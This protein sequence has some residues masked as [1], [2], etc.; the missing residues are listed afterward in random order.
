M[1]ETLVLAVVKDHL[2]MVALVEMVV[3]VVEEEDVAVVLV[4]DG[5][6]DAD[7]EEV[8][9]EEK[10]VGEAKEGAEDVVVDT[11]LRSV[12]NRIRSSELWAGGVETSWREVVLVAGRWNEILSML[13]AFVKWYFLVWQTAAGGGDLDLFGTYAMEWSLA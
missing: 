2:A 1:V 9:G 11:A 4:E 12:Q 13:Q 10:E 6:V 3:L 7:V 5:D 8:V